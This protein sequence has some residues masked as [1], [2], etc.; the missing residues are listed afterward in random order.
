MKN[1]QYLQEKENNIRISKA[2]TQG[3]KP[4]SPKKSGTP[5]S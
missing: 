3:A 4:N 5:H 1:P 2:T